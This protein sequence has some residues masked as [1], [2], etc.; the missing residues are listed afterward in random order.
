MSSKSESNR[1]MKSEILSGANFLTHLLHLANSGIKKRKLG[2]FRHNLIKLLEKRY[3]NYWD[4]SA[5]MSGTGY[6]VIRI[7]E[8]MDPVVKEAAKLC[9]INEKVIQSSFPYVLT[10]WI[11]PNEVTYRFGEDGDIYTLFDGSKKCEAWSPHCE[12]TI[13]T[14]MC[15]F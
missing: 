7:N 8:R 5:P 14:K 13:C 6:R 11:D 2:R 15:C 9:N 4:Y 10:L 3:K 1:I 12:E